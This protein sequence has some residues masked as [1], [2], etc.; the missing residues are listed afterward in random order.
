MKTEDGG[1]Y[2]SG[3][4]TKQNIKR[5]ITGSDDGSENLKYQ[6]TNTLSY[7][8]TAGG[9]IDNP[10]DTIH[11]ESYAGE[12][13]TWTMDY[14][15]ENIACFRAI[16]DAGN[17]SDWTQAYELFIDKTAP[18]I[19][20]SLKTEDGGNYT[21]GTWTKQNIKREIT[22][23]DNGSGISKYQYT[24]TL[25]YCE[26]TTG[27]IDDE[28]DTIYDEGYA[29]KD[30]IW[31]MNYEGTNTACFRVIDKAGNASAWTQAYKLFVDKTAP[32]L[33]IIMKKIGFAT[34]GNNDDVSSYSDYTSGVDYKGGTIFAYPKVDDDYSG[35]ENNSKYV[36][37]TTYGVENN[38]NSTPFYGGQARNFLRKGTTDLTCTAKDKAGNETSKKVTIINGHTHEYYAG[39]Y[40]G[41]D[42]DSKAPYVNYSIGTYKYG[43]I[44]ET[45]KGPWSD[46]TCSETHYYDGSKSAALIQCVHCAQLR[47]EIEDSNKNA[48]WC[49]NRAKQLGFNVYG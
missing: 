23:S 13:V 8:G 4:W 29:G 47:R 40:R 27:A 7:C 46:S 10:N 17:V 45:S 5:E 12:G 35:I 31:T 24:N 36:V 21:S 11:D 2:T 34:K 22:G 30:V 9:E 41:M 25:S 38:R 28:Y 26:T 33:N 20:V 16:D 37:C 42:K 19:T 49:P 43:S 6:Y 32:T 3:T 44:L 14:E 39:T 1:N 15:G 18:T 48:W